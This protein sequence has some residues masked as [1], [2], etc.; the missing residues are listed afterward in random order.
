MTRSAT[1]KIVKGVTIG[2]AFAALCLVVLLFLAIRGVWDVKEYSFPTKQEATAAEF[3][4]KGW[5]PEFI[6]ESSTNI[7]VKRNIDINTSEGG[8]AFDPKDAEPFVSTL[9]QKNTN[10]CRLGQPE[11]YTELRSKGYISIDCS[12]GDTVWRFMIHKELGDCR[13]TS[14]MFKY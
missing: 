2:T 10:E 4:E 14:S 7:R 1:R 5:L 11:N 9:E 8:F 13:Y 12:H 6:P 3:F